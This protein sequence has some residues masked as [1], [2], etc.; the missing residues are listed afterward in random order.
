M[1]LREVKQ[2]AQRHTA[3]EWQRSDSS[4]GRIQKGF[5]ERY[6]L[7]EGAG[8]AK[9]WKRD[10]L[11]VFVAG[12]RTQL[13]EGGLSKNKEDLEGHIPQTGQP[14]VHRVSC[15]AQDGEHRLWG[16]SKDVRVPGLS[17]TDCVTL[18]QIL[19]F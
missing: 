18:T 17:L 13:G 12:G 14:H 3:G 11:A 9:A 4:P 6:D 19:P 1:R 15:R 2:P 16:Q 8:G 7:A 10:E 5:A